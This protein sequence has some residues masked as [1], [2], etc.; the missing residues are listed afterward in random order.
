[1]GK[2]VCIQRFELK[3]PQTQTLYGSG[4]PGTSCREQSLKLDCLLEPRLWLGRAR[5]VLPAVLEHE[6]VG[7]TTPTPSYGTDFPTMASLHRRL[8]PG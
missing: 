5:L 8:Q 3:Q 7:L 2:G 6:A 4:L 1:M